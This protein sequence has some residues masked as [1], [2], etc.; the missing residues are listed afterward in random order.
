MAA[1]VVERAP[2]LAEAVVEQVQPAPR[3]ILLALVMAALVWPTQLPGHLPFTLVVAERKGA[4]IRRLAGPVAAQ[5]QL[6]VALQTLV[7]VA[8]GAVVQV[9][10]A[11]DRVF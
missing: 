6:E 10:E 1:P 11:A 4:L 2:I 5:A 3:A 9:P 7:V 8:A